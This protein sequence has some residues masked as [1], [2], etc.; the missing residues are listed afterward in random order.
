LEKLHE[1]LSSLEA[2]NIRLEAKN[3]QLQLD[4]DM[5]RQTDAASERMKRQIKHME[6]YGLLSMMFADIL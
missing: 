5:T 6:E 1:R 4:S 2:Q 3:L